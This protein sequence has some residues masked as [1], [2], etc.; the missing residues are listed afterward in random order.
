MQKLRIKRQNNC[1]RSGTIHLGNQ[2]YQRTSQFEAFEQWN[3]KPLV[4]MVVRKFNVPFQYYL[5]FSKIFKDP[6]GHAFGR[7]PLNKSNLSLCPFICN[8]HFFNP[9]NFVYF[10]GNILKRNSLK[11][12]IYLLKKSINNK[13]ISLNS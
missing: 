7:L 13:C 5:P 1:I 11:L 8:S 6:W 10:Y 3:S 4:N 9:Q 12:F 2:S